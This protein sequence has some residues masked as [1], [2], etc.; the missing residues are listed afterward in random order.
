M[1]EGKKTLMGKWKDRSLT[2]E[3]IRQIKDREELKGFPVNVRPRNG[4]APPSQ[5]A[6]TKTSRPNRGRKKGGE[7]EEK[8]GISALRSFAVKA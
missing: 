1:S 3:K 5:D 2:P 8:G 6:A 4:L 7:G